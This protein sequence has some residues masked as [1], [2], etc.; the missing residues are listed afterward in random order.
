MKSLPLVTLEILLVN[1]TF[2]SPGAELTNSNGA[3]PTGF[4]G[5]DPN[6]CVAACV[7]GNR[8]KKK[9]LWVYVP[10]VSLCSSISNQTEEMLP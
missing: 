6:S 4:T 9:C 2:S 8:R 1:G 10:C 3:V 5:R 7:M